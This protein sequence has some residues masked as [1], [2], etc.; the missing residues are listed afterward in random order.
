MKKLEVTGEKKKKMLVLGNVEE[1]EKEIRIKF[2]K[3]FEL[4]FSLCFDDACVYDALL[5]TEISPNTLQKMAMGMNPRMGPVMEMLMHG[6]PVMFLEEGLTHRGFKS[7]CPLN[8]YKLYEESVEKIIDLGFFSETLRPKQG[9]LL[10]EE[11]Q[12]KKRRVI[13]ERDIKRLV[14]Q[15]ESSL[16]LSGSPLITPLAKDLIRDYKITL[17]H[18]ERRK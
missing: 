10:K 16:S 7:T 11:T 4:E 15:G 3:T 18:D 5:L 1:M 6:K 2:E 8:L 14:E 12:P 13:T 9:F 17:L